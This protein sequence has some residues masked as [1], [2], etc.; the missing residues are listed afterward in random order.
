M[1]QTYRI[2]PKTQ[3]NNFI[4]TSPKSVDNSFYED[5]PRRILQKATYVAKGNSIS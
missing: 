4:M 2:N 3:L 1:R 5:S